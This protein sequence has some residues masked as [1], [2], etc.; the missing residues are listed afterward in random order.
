MRTTVNI[1]TLRTGN[2]LV[3]P[4]PV[5]EKNGLFSLCN[6]VQ[7]RFFQS[8]TQV[9]RVSV[10]KLLFHVNDPYRGKWIIVKP[11]QQPVI[12]VFSPLG[13]IP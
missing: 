7:D 1:A 12:T 10:E 8:V 3:R 11:M 9:G 4:P 6:A 2:Q 13:M 5:Q